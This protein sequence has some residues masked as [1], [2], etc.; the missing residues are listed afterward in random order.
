MRSLE[1]QINEFM[2]HKLLTIKEDL[3]ATS[4]QAKIKR[5]LKFMLQIDHGSRQPGSEW[6]FKLMGKLNNRMKDE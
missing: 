6:Q 2:N 5:M 3:L 1:D 4:Q